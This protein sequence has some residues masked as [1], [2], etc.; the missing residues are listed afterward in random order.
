MMCQRDNPGIFY[1]FANMPMALVYAAIFASP[2]ATSAMGVDFLGEQT[3]PRRIAAISAGFIGVLIAIDP[4][5]IEFELGHLALVVL[6]ILGA[7]GNIIVRLSGP[8]EALSIMSFWPN[9][10]VMLLMVLAGGSSFEVMEFYALL[11]LMATA[12]CSWFGGV[13]FMHAMRRG[14]TISAISMQYSQVIWGGLLGYF[15]FQEAITWPTFL[16]SSVIVASGLYIMLRAEDRP[17]VPV[18]REV[19]A[20]KAALP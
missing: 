4:T 10:G 2:L 9:L 7:A 5:S 11:I 6:P 19:A 14:P 15:L 16:G 20:P 18:L 13:V 12:L 17:A 3:G 8:Y 1:A